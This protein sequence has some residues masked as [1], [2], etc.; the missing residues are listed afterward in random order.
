MVHGLGI[1][2]NSI[3]VHEYFLLFCRNPKRLTKAVFAINL[4]ISDHKTAITKLLSH[5]H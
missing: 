4:V 5:D 2:P 3:V 1:I